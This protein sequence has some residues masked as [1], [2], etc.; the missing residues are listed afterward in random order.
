MLNVVRCEL[1]NAALDFLTFPASPASRFA[2]HLYPLFLVIL[3]CAQLYAISVTFAAAFAF[4]CMAAQPSGEVSP[5]AVCQATICQ[6][7]HKA[8]C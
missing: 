4:H 6:G 8:L 2:V 1:H 5:E 7:A 3:F